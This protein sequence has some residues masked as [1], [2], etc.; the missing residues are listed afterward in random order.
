MHGLANFSLLD[1]SMRLKCLAEGLD[2][3]YDR[4]QGRC[5]LELEV[6]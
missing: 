4:F 5:S 6:L 3:V 1:L 2:L